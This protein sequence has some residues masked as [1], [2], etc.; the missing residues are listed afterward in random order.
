MNEYRVIWE[1][2]VYA[3]SHEDA[4]K[5]ALNIQRDVDSTATVFSVVSTNGHVRSIDVGNEENQNE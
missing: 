1:I 3:E 4:A 5:Q 2:D